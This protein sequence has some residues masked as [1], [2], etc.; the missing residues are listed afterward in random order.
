[1]KKTAQLMLLL[2]ISSVFTAHAQESD[3]DGNQLLERCSAYLKA[4]DNPP[5]TTA[6][7]VNA[8]FCLG[9]MSAIAD[10]D[11]HDVDALKANS[12]ELQKYF[13]APRNA[14]IEQLVRVVMKWMKENPEKLHYN[15]GR[16]SAMAL[17]AAFPCY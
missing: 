5:L 4:R 14:T 9:Y 1:M 13:C 8:G 2:A 11:A 7:E 16:V 6:E 10:V 3:V 17:H 15:A 12:K